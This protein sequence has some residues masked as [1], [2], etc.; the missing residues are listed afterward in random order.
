MNARGYVTGYIKCNKF[1]YFFIKK[2]TYFLV[3]FHI[4][5]Y[6]WETSTA[7]IFP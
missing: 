4:I 6:G 1:A 7:A 5:N 3:V 2:T